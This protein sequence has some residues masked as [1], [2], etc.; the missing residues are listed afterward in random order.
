MKIKTKISDFPKKININKF[1]SYKYNFLCFKIT[2]YKPIAQHSFFNYF[3][4]LLS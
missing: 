2:S 3:P 1:F 4:E